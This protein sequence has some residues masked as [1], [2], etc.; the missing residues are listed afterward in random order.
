M[1]H[2]ETEVDRNVNLTSTWNR[3]QLIWISR[4]GSTE[5][6]EDSAA[7]WAGVRR[8]QY[9]KCSELKNDHRL[10]LDLLHHYYASTFCIM[11]IKMEWRGGL[12]FQ[13]KRKSQ[14]RVNV[15]QTA[16]HRGHVVSPML[17][18]CSIVFTFKQNPHVLACRIIYFFL[19]W[20]RWAA[21]NEVERRLQSWSATIQPPER[22]Q[23]GRKAGWREAWLRPQSFVYCVG[24]T[25]NHRTRI[26]SVY[27]LVFF[28][29]LCYHDTS[30]GKESLWHVQK[31]TEEAARSAVM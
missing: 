10:P 29:S 27:K 26:N 1:K 7:G 20:Y 25:N 13:Q 16:S 6:D 9:G 3:Q 11:R 15:N 30:N 22:R 4:E 18:L 28:Y 14:S 12:L 17:G 31:F 21:E 2:Y 5:G 8:Q 24:V 19:L 23:R